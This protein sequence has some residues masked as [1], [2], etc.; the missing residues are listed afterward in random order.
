MCFLDYILFGLNYKYGLLI[1]VISVSLI[2]LAV[3]LY[4]NHKKIVHVNL[5]PTLSVEDCQLMTKVVTRKCLEDL[6]KHPRYNEV[7]KIAE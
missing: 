7:K 4:I 2:I 5:A 1:V 6:K 3:L